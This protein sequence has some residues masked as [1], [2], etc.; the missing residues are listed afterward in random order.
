M[1]VLKVLLIEVIEMKN[2]KFEKIPDDEINKVSG[3]AFYTVEKNSKNIFRKY[4]IK[5]W[6]GKVCGRYF[7]K[8]KAEEDAIN[9]NFKHVIALGNALINIVREQEERAKEDLDSN[10]K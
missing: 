6:N 9:M 5:D 7:K 1:N 8:N 4:E 3:G 10:V 2:H